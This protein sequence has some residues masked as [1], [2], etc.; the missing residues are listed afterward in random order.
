MHFITVIK[1]G[2]D[3]LSIQTE[4]FHL[5]FVRLLEMNLSS[6]IL[7]HSI[8]VKWRNGEGSREGNKK[9]NKIT[10]YN[11]WKLRK[12]N[13]LNKITKRDFYRRYKV[14]FLYI[15]EKHR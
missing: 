2:T 14:I 11:E 15:Y 9:V 6:L 13:I 1:G 10:V 7:F 12:S 4:I 3:L 8:G 5:I